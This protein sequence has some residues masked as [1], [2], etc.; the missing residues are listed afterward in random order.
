MRLTN[1]PHFVVFSGSTEQ[2]MDPCSCL[3]LYA[4]VF[5]PVI[6]QP[7]IILTASTA[8]RNSREII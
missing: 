6:E 8:L 5:E 3:C 4:C 7:H 1:Y 2:F